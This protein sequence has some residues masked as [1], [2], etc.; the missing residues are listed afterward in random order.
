[1]R[2]ILHGSSFQDLR[3]L[4]FKKLSEKK[5]RKLTNA[6][7]HFLRIFLNLFIMPLIYY[8]MIEIS[9]VIIGNWCIRRPY[10]ILM[11]GIGTL[12]SL[13][14]IGSLTPRKKKGSYKSFWVTFWDWNRSSNSHTRPCSDIFISC[15]LYS[16]KNIYL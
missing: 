9:L 6:I 7:S 1:M 15:R 4:N 8:L 3:I 14:K 10:K 2:S 16:V 13:I 11:K 5:V 12:T